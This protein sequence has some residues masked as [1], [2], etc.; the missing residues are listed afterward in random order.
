MA[1]SHSRI[2]PNPYR[3]PEPRASGSF[4]FEQINFPDNTDS[5]KC[6]SFIARAE[7]DAA[8]LAAPALVASVNK[9]GE[10][11]VSVNYDVLS[12]KAMTAGR[13]LADAK[14]GLDKAVAAAKELQKLTARN[15]SREGA[16]ARVR[17]IE[18]RTKRFSQIKRQLKT[19]IGDGS[20]E[21]KA[22]AKILKNI[23][24]LLDRKEAM[25]DKIRLQTPVEWRNMP[26]YI[27][28]QT[29]VEKALLHQHDLQVKTDFS[30]N[31]K[32]TISGG[33]SFDGEDLITEQE[34]NE[35]FASASLSVRL[36]VLNPAWSQKQV[37]KLAAAREQFYEPKTGLLWRI[38]DAYRKN[39]IMLASWS[40]K[41]M[42]IR[43]KLTIARRNWKETTSDNHVPRFLAEI[44]IISLKS[45]LIEVDKN[46]EVLTRVQKMLQASD[47]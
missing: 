15:L 23:A 39:E 38:G 40:R 37:S 10:G 12:Y 24:T 1:V 31:I 3:L 17:F 21:E 4:D 13:A 25:N 8:L 27:D 29:V 18:E 28:V 43:D 34:T 20:I 47:D 2:N 5:S 19:L 36:G 42:Q 41:Q 9:E 14:C 11:R 44:E 16:V 46:L 26:T 7:V 6:R 32:L 35:G 22:A 33:Y 30:R 45:E